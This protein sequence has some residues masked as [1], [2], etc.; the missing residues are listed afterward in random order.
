[1][2]YI[3]DEKL[4]DFVKKVYSMS[5]P[6]GMG[7]LHFKEGELTDE[8]VRQII[9]IPE[10]HGNRQVIVRMDYVHGRQCKMNVYRDMEGRFYIEEYWYDHTDY[11]LKELLESIGVEYVRS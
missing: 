3:P 7:I 6:V 11:Q 8:E 5:R 9:N 10:K 2:F 4:V 1:M